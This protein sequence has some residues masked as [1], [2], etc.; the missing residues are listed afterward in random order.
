MVVFPYGSV[1]ARL[2]VPSLLRQVVLPYGSVEQFCAKA[3]E[4][5][6]SSPTIASDRIFMLVFPCLSSWCIR[7]IFV[8]NVHAKMTYL[9]RLGSGQGSSLEPYRSCGAFRK[10]L[11]MLY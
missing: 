3:L 6:A 11:A 10:V 5:A 8:S 4:C 1:D 2:V 9:D 7:A